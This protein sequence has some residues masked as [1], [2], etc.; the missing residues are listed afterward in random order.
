[1]SLLLR[2]SDGV[3]RVYHRVGV[4]HLQAGCLTGW[5][6]PRVGV[7]RRPGGLVRREP[8]SS[9]ASYNTI[10]EHNNG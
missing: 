1:M 3:N 7:L 4:F 8:A 9:N 6:S 10:R 2:L 5:V